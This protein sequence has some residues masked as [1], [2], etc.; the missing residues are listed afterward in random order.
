MASHRKS[1]RESRLGSARMAR[2]R[3]ARLRGVHP[4]PCRGCPSTRMSAAW[5]GMRRRIRS[6]NGHISKRCHS[7]STNG[8]PLKVLKQ[9][10]HARDGTNRLVRSQLPEYAARS[11]SPLKNLA[12]KDR[13]AGPLTDSS[14]RLGLGSLGAT[15]GNRMPPNYTNQ[16]TAQQQ[17]TRPYHYPAGVSVA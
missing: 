13:R 10:A 9:E 8:G 7:S 6:Y 1:M 12:A 2:I 3:A 5:K 15:S 4:C 14:H 17:T 11:R 16:D